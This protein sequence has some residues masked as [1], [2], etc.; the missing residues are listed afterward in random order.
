MLAAAAHTILLAAGS[1][2]LPCPPISPFNAPRRISAGA[3]AS[4][5]APLWLCQPRGTSESADSDRRIPTAEIRVAVDSDL[6]AATRP[7]LS[8]EGAGRRLASHCAGGPTG[9]AHGLPLPQGGSSCC[10]TFLAAAPRPLR[11]AERRE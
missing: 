3:G 4:V 1:T 7:R 5:Q 8:R 9:A 6:R 2:P 11:G 10:A